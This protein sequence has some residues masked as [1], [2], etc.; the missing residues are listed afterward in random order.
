MKTFIIG[1]T[2]L[3]GS[4][5]LSYSL[6]KLKDYNWIDTNDLLLGPSSL[7]SV[8]TVKKRAVVKRGC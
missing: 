4:V 3:C 7:I 8:Q 2:F 5:L 1:S 6:Y